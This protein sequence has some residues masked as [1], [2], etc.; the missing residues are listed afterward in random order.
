MSAAIRDVTEQLTLR[1]ELADARAETE[2]FA[3]RERI[4][5]D[6][7]DH[8][9]QRVFAVG[10]ALEGTMCGPVQPRSSND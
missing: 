1:S 10:L 2:V 7:Q 4:A 9:L 6:L 5:G 8:A 3:E